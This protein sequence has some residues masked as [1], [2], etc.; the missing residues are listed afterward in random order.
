MNDHVRPCNLK[1]QQRDLTPVLRRP[2]EPAPRKRT[3]RYARGMSGSCQQET[4]A[5]Q[6]T[7]PY[8]IENRGRGAS[9]VTHFALFRADTYRTRIYSPL[10]SLGDLFVQRWNARLKFAASLNPSAVAISSFARFV[11][12]RYFRASWAL[13]SSC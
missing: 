11:L 13:S 2:V 1:P 9:S 8:S 5:S 3:S 10:T 6:Q 7:T 4:H 12:R